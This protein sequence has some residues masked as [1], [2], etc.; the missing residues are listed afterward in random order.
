MT[1]SIELGVHHRHRYH[2]WDPRRATGRLLCATSLAVLGALLPIYQL[3]WMLRVVIG[4]DIGALTLNAMSWRF[5]LHADAR[6]TERRA[7]AQDPGRAMVWV[8]VLVASLA[9]L[10][11]SVGALHRVG[12]SPQASW[13]TLLSLI[14]V[15]LAWVLTHTVYTLH[16]AHLY[17]RH[18]RAGGLRFPGDRPPADIDFAY[19][20]FTIGICYQTSDVT[21]SNSLIRRVVLFH[22][23]QSFLFNT[24]ILALALNLTFG[25]LGG[26]R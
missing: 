1:E 18:S 23:V 17:Y 4:W 6:E 13:W 16:Y 2:F 11:A 9:S 19:F 10:F 21:I 25:L 20:A 14:G 12:S 5:I 7:S 3:D 24:T 22:S 15:A 8:M 26:T